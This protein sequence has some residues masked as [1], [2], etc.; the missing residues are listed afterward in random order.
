MSSLLDVRI[1]GE[2]M[3]PT[4]EDGQILTFRTLDDAATLREGEVVLVHHPMK[5]GVVMVKRIVRIEQD[6][7][8]FLSG[9]HPDPLASEDS[10]NFGPV[11]PESVRA[12][13]TG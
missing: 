12:K 9:D 2:S 5:K 10:H 3:W 11:S 8:L 1:Q 7:R 13:W 4:F 6:G